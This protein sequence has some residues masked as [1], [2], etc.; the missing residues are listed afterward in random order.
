MTA[1]RPK[2]ARVALLNQVH[3]FLKERILD[4]TFDPGS[5]LN[6]DALA[7]E[8]SVSST[9][10]RESLSH[11]V[12]EG[13]VRA[14]PFVGFFVS[15]L[16]SREFIEQL[17]DFRMVLEPWAV[18]EM[19]KR[20]P[21]EAMEQLRKAIDAMREG[22]LSKQY[23]GFRGYSEADESFHIAILAGSENEPALKAYKNLTI[24]LHLS[25]LYAERDLVTEK[26][27]AQHVEIHNAVL[28]GASKE[29]SKLMRKH[30]DASKQSLLGK[31]GSD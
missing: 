2:F 24:Q 10:I 23:S 7:R 19:A 25:R 4:R 1:S 17:F 8:L 11:L 15:D 5:N 31:S 12:A 27:F 20:K 14:E 3:E 6:V 28:Q 13:L 30:L 18:G 26:S 16:P 21:P 9:P 29:A 22:R